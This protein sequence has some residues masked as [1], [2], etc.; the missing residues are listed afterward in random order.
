M[1]ASYDFVIVGAGSAGCALAN[2]LSAD[3]TCKVL[4]LEAGAP[5]SSPLIRFPIGELWT[6]GSKLDWRF[7]TEP[8]AGAADKRVFVPRGKVVGGSSAING[9]IYVRG[10]AADFDSWQNLGARGWSYK[11]V[12]PY[13]MRA[14]SWSGNARGIRGTSGPVQTDLGRYRSPIFESFLEAGRQLGYPVVDDY[15]LGDTEGFNWTQYTMEHGRA[16]RCSSAHA[17]LH[18]IRDRKNLTVL[19]RAQVTGLIMQRQTCVGVRYL[20]EGKEATASAGEVVLSA[21]AYLSPQLL[22]LAGIGDADQLRKL[23]ITPLHD[24]KGVGQNLQD[25]CGSL[26]QVRCTK[27]ITFHSIRTNPLRGAAALLEY[28]VHDSGP[29]SVFPM[30]A[31]A[32]V[33]SSSSEPRPDLQIQIYPVTKDISG[34]SKKLAAFNGYGISAGGMRPRSRGTVSLQSKD[35]LQAPLIRHNYLS[36]PYDVAA[37]VAGI[38]LARAINGSGAFDGIRGEEVNPSASAQSDRELE[39]YVRKTVDSQYHPSGTCKMGVDDMAVVDPNLRVH[40]IT[41]LRI[42]DAS[43]MPVVTSGNTNAPAIMI[44]EKASDLILNKTLTLSSQT[45]ALSIRAARG[46]SE[47]Q[48]ESVAVQRTR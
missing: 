47:V 31:Q 9:M 8:E 11:D 15:N 5:D 27:P 14:E 10:H 13:F 1:A 38:R 12:L 34:G 36:D 19:T 25:H 17:Y 48:L 2:R 21:G 45:G 32:F 23:G 22:M 3:P 26:I 44:G 40:G 35:P 4:L 28:L 46:A 7:H 41:G 39:A 42:A 20:H 29:F 16:R 30:A 24:L 18:P 33:R 6:V 43:I 37:L